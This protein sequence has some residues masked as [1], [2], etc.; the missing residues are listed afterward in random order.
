MTD[1]HQREPAAEAQ[2]QVVVKPAESA[3]LPSSDPLL[4]TIVHLVTTVDFNISVTLM[5]GGAQISGQLIGGRHY[6]EGLGKQWLEG[7]TKVGAP[8]PEM[9]TIWRR[10]GEERYGKDAPRPKRYAH[11]H[12]KDAA[13]VLGDGQ[14][15]RHQWWRG[16]LAKG[17][18]WAM[19]AP[20]I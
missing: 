11:I 7:F 6:F 13:V 18:G 8:N 3:S 15:F 9:E 5:V 4:E 20:E 16:R 19:G 12:L 2:E 1:E 10:I 14:V 17:D